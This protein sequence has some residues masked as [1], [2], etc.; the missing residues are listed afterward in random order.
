MMSRKSLKLDARL[1]STVH[2]ASGDADGYRDTQALKSAFEAFKADPGQ[3][4]TSVNPGILAMYR[5]WA[6]ANAESLTLETAAARGRVAWEDGAA[7]GDFDAQKKKMPI[8]KGCAKRVST[9]K[10]SWISMASFLASKLAPLYLN[11]S[12]G[13]LFTGADSACPRVEDAPYFPKLCPQLADIYRFAMYTALAEHPWYGL[14]SDVMWVGIKCFSPAA[15]NTSRLEFDDYVWLQEPFHV[16]PLLNGIVNMVDGEADAIPIGKAGTGV[17]ADRFVSEA[18]NPGEYKL[19][20]IMLHKYDTIIAG[21]GG[22][23][24]DP[25]ARGVEPGFVTHVGYPDRLKGTFDPKY[26]SLDFVVPIEGVDG[27]APPTGLANCLA[28]AGMECGP[29]TS[30]SD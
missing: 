11:G 17:K 20:K 12:I 7:L 19:V 26:I 29:D 5:A 22:E 16:S 21:D 13:D 27:G 30:G 8:L 23:C 3:N 2:R 15:K 14:E 9:P 25:T 10:S 18:E 4:I 24:K 28:Y 1:Q 6:A